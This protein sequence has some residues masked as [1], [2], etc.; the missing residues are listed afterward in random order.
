MRRAQ[1]LK[2]S[3]NPK[4]SAQTL[5]LQYSQRKLVVRNAAD[6]LFPCIFVKMTELTRMHGDIASKS[7]LQKLRVA[8]VLILSA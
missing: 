5:S 1:P 4:R 2:V 3:G 6:R 8:A 7:R